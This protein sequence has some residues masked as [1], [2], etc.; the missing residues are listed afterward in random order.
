MSEARSWV[1]NGFTARTVMQ[2]NRTI[3]W[4][5]IDI[6]ATQL[7]KLSFLYT[8]SWI[9]LYNGCLKHNVVSVMHYTAGTV[10]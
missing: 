9:K 5:S 2:D 4:I 7:Q 1:G 6:I 3:V 10:M 8:G